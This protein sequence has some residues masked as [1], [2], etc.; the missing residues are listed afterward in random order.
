[1]ADDGAKSGG[2]WTFFTNHAH[3]LFCLAR[4]PDLRIRDIAE[5][6]GITERATQRIIHELEESGYLRIKREGR[7]N[8]YKLIVSKR[9]R[10]PVEGDHNVRDLITFLDS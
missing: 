4:D 10:H 5:K 2:V 6:V 9:L 7:R 8:H 3:V 1:V